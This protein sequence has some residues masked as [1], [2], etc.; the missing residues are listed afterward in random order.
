M[1]TAQMLPILESSFTDVSIV[2]ALFQQ[3]GSI[4]VPPMNALAMAG[5]G[6]LLLDTLSPTPAS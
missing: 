1:H 6:P 3:T 2:I 4:E 5:L